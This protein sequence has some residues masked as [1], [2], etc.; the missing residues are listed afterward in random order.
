MAD[1][2]PHPGLN[3]PPDLPLLAGY[4]EALRAQVRQLLVEGRLAAHLHAR[5]PD[6]HTVR[7]DAAL[8]AH[9]M[10]LKQRHLRNAPPL[11]KVVYDST[12]RRAQ[13]ALGT[14]TTVSRVQGNRLKAKREIRVAALFRDAPAAL[15]DMIVVHELAHLKEAAHD[16]AFYALCEHMLPG[17]RQLEFDTRLYLML[18]ARPAPPPTAPAGNPP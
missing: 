3:G 16:K 13:Q 18:P 8:Y 12:L 9:A 2:Q 10:A 4:P 11:A 17:Y 7:T 6:G 1:T 5:H 14:L 15:L